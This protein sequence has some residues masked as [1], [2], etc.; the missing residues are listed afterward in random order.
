MSGHQIRCIVN[1]VCKYLERLLSRESL[2]LRGFHLERSN[3]DDSKVGNLARKILRHFAMNSNYL[4]FK[5]SA[6]AAG[7]LMLSLNIHCS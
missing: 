6:M 7:V 2:V 4:K 1:F 3:E 5:P